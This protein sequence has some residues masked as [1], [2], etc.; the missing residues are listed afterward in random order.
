M[1]Y[2]AYDFGV[3]RLLLSSFFYQPELFR[4]KSKQIDKYHFYLSAHQAIFQIL[5]D[6]D[7]GD[8]PFDEEL[9]KIELERRGI[10]GEQPLIEILSTIPLAVID[11]HLEYLKELRLKRGVL[12]LSQEVRAGVLESN[13]SASELI[14]KLQKRLEE[15]SQQ[16]KSEWFEILALHEIEAY[17]T[18]FILTGWLP[19]PRRTVSILTAPGGTGKSWLVLQIALRFLLENESEKAFL[20]LSEDPKELTKSRALKVWRDVLFKQEEEDKI[21]PRLF[22]SDSPTFSV[23]N[24]QGRGVEISPL[25]Y[26]LKRVLKEYSLI[27]FDPLIAFFGGDE[28]NNSQARKFMQLFTEWAAKEGKVLIFVHHSS[29]NTTQARGASAFVDAV[30]LV[31]EV[32]FIKKEDEVIKDHARRLHLTKDNYGAKI[33]LGDKI[34]ER[35]IFPQELSPRPSKAVPLPPPH[36]YIQTQDELDDF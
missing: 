10:N 27:V 18:E 29:K 19:F 17:Q 6:L 25:F 5:S 26:Q 22:I 15:I 14:G 12:H 24:E 36:T 32:D 9:I 21:A 28:N 4:Q 31:Y 3:E 23:L 8:K 34:V 30:R 1:N 16:E 35:Q 7:S 11:D 2:E 13:L 20:W 33:F